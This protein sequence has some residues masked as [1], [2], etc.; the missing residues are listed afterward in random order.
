MLTRRARGRAG[1]TP[2][3]VILALLVLGTTGRAQTS[4]R[5]VMPEPGHEAE[6]RAGAEGEFDTDASLETT[7][8]VRWMPADK[9]RHTSTPAA[10]QMGI[11]TSVQVNVSQSR[12]NIL[13][14]AANEPSLAIDPTKPLRMVIGWR[15]FDSVL[16]DFRQAGWAYSRDGGRTWRFPG[17]LDP[18]IFRSDPVLAADA[19]GSFYY[20]SLTSEFGSL[21]VDFF[22]ANDGGA[23]WSGPWDAYGGDKQWFTIDRTGG[24]GD[25]NLYQAWSR[26]GA[27]CGSNIF[28]RSTTGAASWSQPVAVPGTPRWGT[29]AV[30]RHGI[31]YLAGVDGASN[32]I[33]A[34][35]TTV[36]DA[37][38]LP[39]FDSAGSVDMG[40]TIS[41][42][43]GGLNPNPAGLLG[44]AWI[45]V[46][47][48]EQPTADWVYL[49]CSVNP[50]GPDP[51]D[52]MFSRSEDG[53]ATWRAPRKLNDDA[54]QGWQWGA[55][56]SVA[57]N[58]RIDV[59]WN[60]TRNT[61]RQP[62]CAVLYLVG[63]RR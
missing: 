1:W 45:A 3:V 55:T 28:T 8:R 14:D 37:A 56:M 46:D 13:G 5:V 15:Q 21:L 7:P 48:S 51:L 39:A 31:L 44:Q 22:V 26:A 63:G 35:S 57:P 24:I 10:F 20:S 41:A 53:G 42:V 36:K 18:G 40:G 2:R 6:L 60:D 50:P 4:T 9:P 33:V 12:Q 32:F 43:V 30:D 38:F 11:A 54:T 49:V 34:K 16:S 61:G 17:V 62:Q 25:G 52:V 23:I 59:V 19:Q 47:P 58:G 27:C 29:L